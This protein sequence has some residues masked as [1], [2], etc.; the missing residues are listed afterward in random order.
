MTD[1]SLSR[2]QYA[3]LAAFR[4]RLRKFLQFSETA[5]ADA[6]LPAQQHQALLA[7]AGYDGTEPPSVGVLAEQLL[8]APH[9]AAELVARMVGSG[10]LIK[11]VSASDRRRSDL[12]LTPKA[13]TLL[14]ALTDVHL[15]ELEELRSALT[16]VERRPP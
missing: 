9:T 5:A 2:Q 13:A 1:V 14:A 10:L 8:V 11:A 6:G 16:L 12:S 3:A 15:R 7:L 4:H